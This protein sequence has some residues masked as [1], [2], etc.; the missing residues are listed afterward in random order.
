MRKS[1]WICIPL[2]VV[3]SACNLPG[4]VANPTEE[5]KPTYVSGALSSEP[6]L[7]PFQPSNTSTPTNTATL[8]PTATITQTPSPTITRTPTATLI[9]GGVGPWT[10]DSHINP[11]TGLSVEN[12]DQLSGRPIAVKISNYPRQIRPQWGLSLADLVFEYYHEGGLTRFH[13]IF[14]GNDANMLGPI[15]SARVFDAQLVMAYRSIFTFGSADERTLNFLFEHDFDEYLVY[16][17]SNG[18]PPLCRYDPYGMNHLVSTT[19]QIEAY[20]AAHNIPNERV[21]LSGMWFHPDVPD[22]GTAGQRIY[23]RYSYADYNRW[24][25]N[26]QIGRYLRYQETANDNNGLGTNYEPQID[27]IT[28]R[29][30]FADNVIVVFVPHEFVIEETDDRNEV[31]DM[32]FTGVGRAIAFR[33]GQ[34]YDVCWSHTDPESILTLMQPSDG[35][36]VPGGYPYPFK[37]GTTWFQLVGET[38]ILRQSGTDWRFEFYIP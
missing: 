38:T 20:I 7:T 32:F 5:N 30:L 9:P 31:I 13:A 37:P 8:L 6:S 26:T 18:C 2:L 12:V 10:F 24:I 4:A 28:G 15:R 23:V 33:D 21:S 27:R 35:E 3:L 19:A 1:M 36:C 17:M 34:A 25:Y 14:Y 22:F 11:L 29:Y 16:P